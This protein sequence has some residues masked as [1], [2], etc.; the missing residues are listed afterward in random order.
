[1]SAPNSPKASFR[2]RSATHTEKSRH[3]SLSGLWVKLLRKVRKVVGR[4]FSVSKEKSYEKL[5]SEYEVMLIQESWKPIAV[6]MEEFGRKVYKRVFECEPDLKIFFAWPD[7]KDEELE[8]I[9][10]FRRQA[11]AIISVIDR[12]VKKVEN[13][14]V[15]YNM[16]HKTK[17][18]AEENVQ[19]PGFFRN[20]SKHFNEISYYSLV[21]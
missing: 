21:T 17:P 14:E 12:C 16:L 11:A 3:L 8:Y 9:P 20:L 7:I 13:I 15:V 18:H 1:M 2:T 5:L 6:D 4:D 19:F 10:E